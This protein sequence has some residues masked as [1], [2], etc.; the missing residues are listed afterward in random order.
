MEEFANALSRRHLWEISLTVTGNRL[1]WIHR[2]FHAGGIEAVLGMDRSEY[3]NSSRKLKDVKK[4]KR[5][6]AWKYRKHDLDCSSDRPKPIRRQISQRTVDYPF[7]LGP[8]QQTGKSRRSNQSGVVIS[9]VRQVPGPGK[10]FGKSQPNWRMH[11][12]PLNELIPPGAVMGM[13]STP[14]LSGA[15]ISESNVMI[16]VKL[17]TWTEWKRDR[18][19]S[20]RH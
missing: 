19:V 20:D 15:C 11:V 18:K 14:E 3:R 6:L 1:S 9:R 12:K 16:R 5:E 4:K 8:S 17:L 7:I 2:F 13:A 10:H